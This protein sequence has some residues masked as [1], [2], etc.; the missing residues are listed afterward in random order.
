ML[1]KGIVEEI[2]EDEFD[3]KLKIFETSFQCEKSIKRFQDLISCFLKV[4]KFF[5][6]SV[7]N[8]K[9]IGE[10]REEVRMWVLKKNLAEN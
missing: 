1:K 6:E 3:D 10:L 4:R 9:K 2:F 8:M 7:E 5:S